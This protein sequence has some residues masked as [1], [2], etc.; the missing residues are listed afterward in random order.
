MYSFALEPESLQPSGHLNCSRIEKMHLHL[1]FSTP[2]PS[3]EFLD[4]NVFAHS[5]NVVKIHSG[6][7]S[8]AWAS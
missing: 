8:L 6:I 2:I 5:Y 3:G 1:K 7:S 4:L